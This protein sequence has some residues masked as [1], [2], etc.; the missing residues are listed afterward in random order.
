MGKFTWCER[1]KT[2]TLEEMSL[3]INFS[4]VSIFWTRTV[5]NLNWEAFEM[6]DQWFNAAHLT[7]VS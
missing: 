6:W 1:Y 7:K 3:Q 5:E 4:G 2:P